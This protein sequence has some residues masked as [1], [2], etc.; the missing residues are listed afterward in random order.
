MD[1]LPELLTALRKSHCAFMKNTSDPTHLSDFHKLAA[2]VGAMVNELHEKPKCINP[3]VLR[4]V[5]QSIDYLPMLLERRP[6]SVEKEPLKPAS[7]W[8]RMRKLYDEV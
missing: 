2:A 4:T 7:S 3:S 8:W 5:G 6:S 1:A